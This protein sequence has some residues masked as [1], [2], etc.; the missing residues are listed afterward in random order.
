MANDVAGAF[1]YLISHTGNRLGCITTALSADSLM[2]R[3]GTHQLAQV[4]GRLAK[5]T[6]SAGTLTQAL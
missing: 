2:P 5:T 6:D 4:L 1:G 3:S